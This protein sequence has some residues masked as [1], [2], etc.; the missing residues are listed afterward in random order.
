MI[1]A[2]GGTA[3]RP[4]DQLD[5]TVAAGRGCDRRLAV[6]LPPEP[7]VAPHYLGALVLVLPF[8]GVQGRR[9]ARA[10]RHPAPEFSPHFFVLGAAFLLLETRSL[11]TFSL[12]FGSTWIVNSLAFFAI[13]ASVLLAI[14]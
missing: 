3:G 8:A 1:D 14:P 13:L 7:F 11:V 2:L 10:R 12:L 4:V 6:P 9:A 5:P